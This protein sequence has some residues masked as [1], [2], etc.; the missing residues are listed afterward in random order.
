MRKKAA[1]ERKKKTRARAEI[2]EIAA[3]F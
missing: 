2:D 3:G 1:K